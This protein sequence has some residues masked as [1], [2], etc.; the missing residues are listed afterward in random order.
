MCFFGF[1]FFFFRLVVHLG[2]ASPAPRLKLVKM[3]HGAMGIGVAT[4]GCRERPTLLCGARAG[5][6]E[7]L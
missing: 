2:C 3:L 7:S 6:R 1:V 5:A 4:L